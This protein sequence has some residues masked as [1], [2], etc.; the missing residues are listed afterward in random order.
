LIFSAIKSALKKFYW[1][2]FLLILQAVVRV[3]WINGFSNYIELLQTALISGFIA[4]VAIFIL[5]VPLEYNRFKRQAKG[6]YVSDI[7]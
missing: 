5:G 4:I 1:I 3:I 7:R 6:F 2:I